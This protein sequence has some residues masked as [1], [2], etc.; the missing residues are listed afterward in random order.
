MS[1]KV[2]CFVA[3][4]SEPIS[5]AESIETA[6]KEIAGGG[7][8]EMAEW[9]KVRVGGRVIIGAICDEIRW[10]QLFI[11][12]V[13]GLNPNVLFELGYA[14]ALR[15][16]VWLLFDPNI[17]RAKQDFDRFQLLTTIGYS[18][19]S[20]SRDIIGAFYRDQPYS[21][22]DDILLSDLLARVSQE[23]SLGRPYC[24]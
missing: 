12:D 22:L 21:H 24:I 5:R 3:Y 2:R 19:F 7:I 13:T 6:T 18:P 10:C 11:A 20:N 1:D 23:D 17:D 4:A 8:V 14:I 16:R 9:K 15:K